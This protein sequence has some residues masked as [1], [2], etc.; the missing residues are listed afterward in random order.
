MALEYPTSVALALSDI[1][2]SP[3]DVLTH[4]DDTDAPGAFSSEPYALGR[5]V[6]QSCIIFRAKSTYGNSGDFTGYQPAEG[7]D[8]DWGH[9]YPLVVTPETTDVSYPTIARDHEQQTAT[10][11]P[12]KWH[13]TGTRKDTHKRINFRA[14]YGEP[15]YWYTAYGGIKVYRMGYE[16]LWDL[17]GLTHGLYSTATAGVVAPSLTP[18]LGVLTLLFFLL[19]PAAVFGLGQSAATGN[20]ATTT[21]AGRRRRKK[22]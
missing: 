11:D 18:L 12:T 2:N 4:L 17:I 13:D 14:V 20:V 8:I 7:G 1:G 22:S 9:D 19:L 10:P 5:T 16:V 3:G 6:Y 21:A 15:S